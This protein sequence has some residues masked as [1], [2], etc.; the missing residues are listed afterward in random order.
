MFAIYTPQRRLGAPVATL[1][2]PRV[3]VKHESFWPQ[4]ISPKVGVNGT[5][6]SEEDCCCLQ[7]RIYQLGDERGSPWFNDANL[8]GDPDGNCGNINR[9]AM[10]FKE[11]CSVQQEKSKNQ[12]FDL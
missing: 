6:D 12:L 9:T 10:F 11:I 2:K 8:P 4:S 1:V 3:V 5:A 7:S